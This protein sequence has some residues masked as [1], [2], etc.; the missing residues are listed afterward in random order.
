MFRPENP[1]APRDP[2]FDEA[3]QAQVLAIADTMV[4]AG[5]FSATAWAETLGAELRAAEAAGKPDTTRTYYEA[6]LAALERLTTE[7]TEITG[8]D[9]SERKATWTRA[10]ERTPHGQPV[11]LERGRDGQS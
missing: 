11:L 8:T 7:A 9:L 10:Y 3:W 6:A 5:R 2:V 1:L 4:Q